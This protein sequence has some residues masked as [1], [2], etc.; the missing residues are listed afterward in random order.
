MTGTA[1][2]SGR[3][4]PPDGKYTA[5][6]T[7]NWHSC[8]I[9]ADETI[10]CW[11]ANTGGQADP[12]EGKYTA[13]AAGAWHTC[14]ISADQTIDC[15]GNNN[16]RTG[17]PL[18]ITDP[19]AGKYT[20]IAAGWYH[21]C[22]IAVDQTIDCWGSN[23]D[24]DGN[25]LG[26]ARPARRPIQ[27]YCHRRLALLRHLS[28]PD[29]R[30]LGQ[31]QRR[32][33][34]IHRAANTPTS[35]LAA[36]TPAPSQPTKPSDCWGDNR[37]GQADPLS[38]Q[39]TPDTPIADGNENSC[40]SPPSATDR[41]V[42]VALYCATG[43]PDWSNNTNWLSDEPLSKWY[44]VRTDH[45]GRVTHV[46]LQEN[47]LSGE[48]PPELGALSNLTSLSLWYNQLSGTIPSELGNLAKL[49]WLYLND[50]QLSGEIPPELGALS[51][52]TSLWLSSNQLSGTIPKRIGQPRQAG[53]AI[54][55]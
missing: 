45:E 36:G 34:P 41:S 54:S 55:Q 5:I 15:W 10:D 37:S 33:G 9:S 17:S 22:A 4:T 50:N 14:A 43:G 1:T 44:G 53:M 8:A 40:A 48:I 2:P 11:G 7:G 31:Q 35:P 28:R 23:N 24:I 26:Q 39:Y 49:E 13:I 38:G 32:S 47:Q 16:D 52:L 25:P 18:G 42:L 3:P 12:P 20:A 30:L 46:E 27:R 21:S 6:A 29:H 19:P 51:N